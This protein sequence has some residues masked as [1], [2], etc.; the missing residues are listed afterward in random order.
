MSP[1]FMPKNCTID[2]S[3][4]LMKNKKTR[5]RISTTASKINKDI[6]NKVTKVKKDLGKMKVLFAFGR[7]LRC[8]KDT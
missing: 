7:S 6:S 4:A 8:T 3:V 1:K 2:D 5:N